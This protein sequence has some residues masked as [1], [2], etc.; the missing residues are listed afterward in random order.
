M[1]SRAMLHF[2]K[3]MLHARTQTHTTYT[4]SHIRGIYPSWLCG[5][6]ITLATFT[7]GARAH[8]SLLFSFHFSSRKSFSAPSWLL[9]QGIPTFILLSSLL[10]SYAFH[11]SSFSKE[12]YPPRTEETL[13]VDRRSLNST[14]KS[15]M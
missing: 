8:F 4:Y 11:F 2:R 10:S 5:P 12:F 9:N 6:V 1:L 15:Q 14:K 7:T 3:Q 13:S